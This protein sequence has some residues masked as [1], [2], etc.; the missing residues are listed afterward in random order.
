MM[1]DSLDRQDWQAILAAVPATAVTTAK[2]GR[3][4]FRQ[5]GSIDA[6]P[7]V[8]L[9]GIGSGSGSFAFVLN[10]LARHYRVI[11]WDAP[12]YGDSDGLA[13]PDPTPADYAEALAD[14]LNTLFLPKVLLL[15]HS[16][17][18]LIGGA[19]AASHPER[20]SKLILACTA[21]GHARLAAEDREAKLAARLEVFERLGPD[22]H[23]AE[24][25][26]RLLGLEAAEN[27]KALGRYNMARLRADGYRAAAHCLSVGDLPDD[28]AAITAPTLV[29]AGGA[30]TITPPA[31]CR[32]IADAIGRGTP[33]VEIPGA[34]HACYVDRPDAFLSIVLDF[35]GEAK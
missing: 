30:D 31:A 3:L 11:A 23:A 6:P 5:A 22:A 2:H 33:C 35:L 8:L 7:L 26:H 27:A 9:H 19:F 28:C 10:I 16:L 15:G 24:R 1:S 34:G 12:G 20:V 14:L 21:H 32:A 4:S 17:G 25:A 29:I 18:A 13:K